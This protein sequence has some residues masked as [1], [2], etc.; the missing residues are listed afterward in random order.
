MTPLRTSEAIIEQVFSSDIVPTAD[1]TYNLGSPTNKFNDLY[2]SGDSIFLGE[3]VL[4]EDE[5]VLKVRNA[6]ESSE[7]AHIILTED[8]FEP[9]NFPQF[10][11]PTGPQGATGPTGPRGEDGFV[12][13]DGADG[14][15]GPV[16]PTGPQGDIGPT[17]E[18]GAVGPTGPFGLPVEVIAG[19]GLTG[20]GLLDQNRTLDI[21]TSIV[22]TKTG[23]QTIAGV[24]TF[25]GSI[26]ASK[27]GGLDLPENSNDAASKVYVDNI[28]QGIKAK[29]SALVLTDTNLSVTY[30][31]EPDLHELTSTINGPFPT[32]DDINSTILNVVGARILVGGQT[33]KEE[34]G[35]Y[36][37]KEA[38]DASNPWVLRRCT[39]CD[40]S[41][42]IPGSYIFITKGTQYENTG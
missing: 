26:V 14:P 29:T 3:V 10:V 35:L 31:T 32:T 6:S 37:L 9:E 39:Q 16:G 21:D 36:V 18:T 33:N 7:L 24:K 1:E 42:K 22:V 38:G 15:T 40:T 19:N 41:E 4:Q 34:N 17:G 5:G 11:G 12:G 8:N 30:D 23:N 2:L 25:T 28:A 20:G 27:I 13:S